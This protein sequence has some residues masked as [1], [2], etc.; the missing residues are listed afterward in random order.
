MDKR[1]LVL[2]ALTG[3][4]MAMLSFPDGSLSVLLVLFISIPAVILLQKKHEKKYFLVNIFLVGLLLRLWL[5]IIIHVFDLR[6]IFGPDA[7][8]Y[9][10]LGQRL[11]EI[12]MG[13]QV[14]NDSRTYLATSPDHVGWGM[15]RLVA[16]IYLI[17]G[18]TILVAQSFCAVIGA[19]TAPMTYIC[20]EKIF[21]NERVSKYSAITIAVFPS[22]V[23]WSS[24]LLKDGLIIFLLV[25][26]MILVLQLQKKLSYVNIALLILS[27]FSIYV[28][29]FYIFYMVAISVVGSFFISSASSINVMIRNIVIIIFLGISLTYLGVIRSASTNLEFYGNLERIQISRQ[30]LSRSAESGFGE[31]IDVSTTSGVVSAIPIGLLYLLFSPFPWQINKFSQLVIMPETILWWTLIPVLISGIIYTLKNKLRESIPVLLFCLMLTISYSIFQGNVGMLYRQRTQIQVFLF[32]FIAVGYTLI[33]ER[34]ENK[35]FIAQ[36]RER[37]LR[38][39]LQIRST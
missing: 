28:L 37:E 10:N 36:A 23:I 33:L 7:F 34:R 13:I 5:G 20:A 27:V 2:T 30:D 14:P 22:F 3:L 16:A 15:I 25:C 11:R 12:W 8:T 1:I 39:K 6:D 9:N 24:Q 21:K 26:T 4:G 18:Q 35:R 17:F 38:R 31:D 32:I 19:L 29:R